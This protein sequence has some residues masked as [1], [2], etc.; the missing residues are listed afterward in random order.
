MS[1]NIQSNDNY[2]DKLAKLLPAEGIAALTTV[3]SLIP[4]KGRDDKVLIGVVLVVAVFVYLWASRVRGVSAPK[5]FVFL[6]IAYFVWAANIFSVRLVNYLSDYFNVGDIGTY[7]P[8]L[9]AILLTLFIPFV[10]PEP[11]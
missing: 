11:A 8:A 9:C 4:D 1:G 6:L 3:N 2:G 10:F 7:L 5:Q